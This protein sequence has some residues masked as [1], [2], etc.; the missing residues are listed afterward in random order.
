MAVSL[1]LPPVA[2]VG[3]QQAQQPA[4]NMQDADLRAFIQDVSRATRTTFIVD[5]R[6]Q[7]TVSISRERDMSETEMLGVLLAV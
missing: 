3:A 5:P 1:L 2:P 6:V 7:G 4:L